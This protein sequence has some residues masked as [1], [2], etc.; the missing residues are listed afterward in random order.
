MNQLLAQSLK[1]QITL[2]ASNWNLYIF[3]LFSGFSVGYRSKVNSAVENW[4]KIPYQIAYGWRGKFLKEKHHF[5]RW[6]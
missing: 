3:N 4:E 2:E 6:A 1:Y 5:E